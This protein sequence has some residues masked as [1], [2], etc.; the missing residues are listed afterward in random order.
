MS[1]K[2]AERRELVERIRHNRAEI[3]QF[4][5]DI[6]H[7]NRCVRKESEEPIDPDPDGLLTRIA[8]AYDKTLAAEDEREQKR[9]SV[10]LKL[11]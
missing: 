2:Y 9:Q 6:D 10:G 5:L 4:F 7:W 8:A 3:R 1:S 11:A